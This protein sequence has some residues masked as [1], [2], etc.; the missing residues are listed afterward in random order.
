[1][2][3]QERDADIWYYDA[4]PFPKPK[5]T[6]VFVDEEWKDRALNA[7]A[8]I[9]NLSEELVLAKT[10]IQGV[11]ELHRMHC[12]SCKECIECNYLIPCPTIRAIDNK[13]DLE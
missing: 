1:M 8:K 7:E 12:G 10:A 5:I 11:R 3:E 13:G 9:I 6:R 2:D 4:A